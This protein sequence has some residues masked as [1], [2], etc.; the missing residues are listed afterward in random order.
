M[1]AIM[2]K[3]A[4][5][6]T[7]GAGSKQRGHERCFFFLLLQNGNV[8]KERDSTER[9]K[10]DGWK[11]GETQ[12]SERKRKRGKREEKGRQSGSCFDRFAFPPHHHHHPPLALCLEALKHESL[13]E[14]VER[15]HFNQI[16]ILCKAG[17][18]PLPTFNH[19]PLFP[20][21]Y[22]IKRIQPRALKCKKNNKKN[23]HNSRVPLVYSRCSFSSW[24][25]RWA[26][27]SWTHSLRRWQISGGYTPFHQPGCTP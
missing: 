17:L 1:V 26:T 24:G 9:T 19:W 13:W 23:T 27:C 22:K 16:F 25:G 10:T 12:K 14:G 21:I 15:Q 5:W 11:G 8:H 2:T 6:E 3:A 4:K 18:A 20:L 7:K